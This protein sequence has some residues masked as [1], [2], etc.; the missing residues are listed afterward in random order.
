MCRRTGNGDCDGDEWSAVCDLCFDVS[1]IVEVMVSGGVLKSLAFRFCERTF[2]ASI[3][4]GKLGGSA[5]I[6]AG[7]TESKR[8]ESGEGGNCGVSV[9]RRSCE[10]GRSFSS[11]KD[12]KDGLLGRNGVFGSVVISSMRDGDRLSRGLPR[13]AQ[14]APKESP[15]TIRKTK[16]PRSTRLVRVSHRCKGRHPC[17]DHNRLTPPKLGQSVTFPQVFIGLPRNGFAIIARVVV[18]PTNQDISR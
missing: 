7:L 6:E 5:G 12:D 4:L 9:S 17:R 10:D 2:G 11:G 8:S 14:T 1:F 18:L 3:F 16:N 13:I 15:A